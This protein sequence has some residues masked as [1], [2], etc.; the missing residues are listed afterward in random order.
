[1]DLESLADLPAYG[2]IRCLR[3]VELPD[4][5]E[6]IDAGLTFFDSLEVGEVLLVEGSNSFAYFGELM[7]EMG[8]QKGVEAAVI[9]GRTRDSAAVK[10]L[11]FPVFAQGTTPVDIKGRGRVEGFDEGVLVGGRLV[12]PGDW[13][14]ADR[15]GVVA[16]PASVKETIESLVLEAIE[17][18]MSIKSTIRAGRNLRDHHPDLE[19]L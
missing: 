2:P 17:F 7:A 19:G 3:V 10:S 9:L 6:N 18:E 4:V 8:L 5:D 12:Q 11:G 14:F 15:D 16:F 13:V 1:M